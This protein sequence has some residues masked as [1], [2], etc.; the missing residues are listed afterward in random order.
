MI[1][2][3]ATPPTVVTEILNGEGM[4]LADAARLCPASRGRGKVSPTTLLRWITVG[5][6]RWD[7]TLVRLE[8]ARYGR[9]WVT[10]RG[11]VARLL[12]ALTPCATSVPPPTTSA[13][14]TPNP[15]RVK[16]AAEKLAAAGA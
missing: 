9:R 15:K 8:A 14:T 10:T 6:P 7:G 16:A 3:A 11:A 1:Q 12:L 5:A 13:N 2:S 4:T